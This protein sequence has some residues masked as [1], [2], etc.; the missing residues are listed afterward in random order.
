MDR[1]AYIF[2]QSNESMG[3]LIRFVWIISFCVSFFSSLFYLE[4]MTSINF[5]EFRGFVE[6]FVDCLNEDKNIYI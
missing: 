4:I 6:S 3:L 5:R 2:L 1:F